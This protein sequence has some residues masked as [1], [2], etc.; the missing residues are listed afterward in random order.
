MT[1]LPCRGRPGK[2][3][4]NSEHG[5]TWANWLRSVPRPRPRQG[6]RRPR[7]RRLRSDSP[8]LEIPSRT[9]T[10]PARMPELDDAGSS[11]RRQ[12][13]DA[14]A[15]A[16][17][18][19]DEAKAAATSARVPP[20]VRYWTS[21]A[22][23]TGS[24]G[25]PQKREAKPRTA[26]CRGGGREEEGVD[27]R[28]PADTAGHVRRPR[29]ELGRGRR[30]AERVGEDGLEERGVVGVEAVESVGRHHQ[31]GDLLG[32]EALL[33]QVDPRRD[34]GRRAVAAGERPIERPDEIRLIGGRVEDGRRQDRERAAAVQVVHV[35]DQS[36]RVG[37]TAEDRLV[38]PGRLGDR[39]IGVRPFEGPKSIGSGRTAVGDGSTPRSMRSGPIM[40]AAQS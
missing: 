26:S 39:Q 2:P 37:R 17:K 40:A 30:A 19:G 10:R 18:A 27:H 12:P 23:V 35:G 11:R 5:K 9:E 15:L 28:R 8:D 34:F 14:A 6:R 29:G 16:M 25:T 32:A 20:A 22:S 33:H 7:G 13:T 31:V 1:L 21:A 24:I 36:G 4:A 38:K 3:G